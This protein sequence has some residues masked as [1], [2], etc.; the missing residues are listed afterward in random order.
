MSDESEALTPKEGA[1]ERVHCR[2]CKKDS[3]NF[4]QYCSQY[5]NFLYQS[6]TC[7][8]T[9]PMITS[10][11]SLNTVLKITV[12]RSAFAPTYLQFAIEKLAQMFS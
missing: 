2:K 11:S 3:E 7:M 1:I 5:D 12:T 8:N 10:S 9:F 6:V 4:S